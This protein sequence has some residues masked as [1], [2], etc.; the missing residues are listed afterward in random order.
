M[1]SNSI[2]VLLLQVWSTEA[3]NKQTCCL[4]AEGFCLFVLKTEVAIP[5]EMAKHPDFKTFSFTK[6][7]ANKYILHETS[8]TNNPEVLHFRHI[9]S[10]SY[11][12]H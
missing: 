10:T 3:K 1:N 6:H 5:L 9:K 2:L 8:K 12:P 11:L 4:Q 7:K